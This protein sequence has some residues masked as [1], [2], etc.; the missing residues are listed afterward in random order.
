MIFN[1]L[2]RV[3]SRIA[4]LDRLKREIGSSDYI[5]LYIALKLLFI[6]NIVR[7]DYYTILIFNLILKTREL[8]TLYIRKTLI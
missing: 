8:L 1:Y 3:G 7:V 4:R 5:F 2:N 6:F